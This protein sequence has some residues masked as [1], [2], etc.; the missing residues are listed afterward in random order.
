M[1]ADI[2]EILYSNCRYE[3][4]FLN[5]DNTW[6]IRS[7][8]LNFSETKLIPLKRKYVLFYFFVSNYPYQMVQAL[9]KFMTNMMVWILTL[10]IFPQ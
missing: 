2:I 8:Q 5:T 3:D 10:L 1:K 7:I 9:S 4:E 6:L